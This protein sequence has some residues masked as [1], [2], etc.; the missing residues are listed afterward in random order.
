VLA[1]ST[2]LPAKAA[3]DAVRLLVWRVN[4]AMASDSSERGPGLLE[5]VPKVGHSPLRSRNL[6]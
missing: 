3:F 2:F 5:L 4:A 1:P 6:A